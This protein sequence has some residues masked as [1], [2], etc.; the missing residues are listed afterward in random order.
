ML[1]LVITVGRPTGQ[2]GDVPALLRTADVF[3]FTT[4]YREGIPR[5]LLEARL[6]IVGTGLSG[7]TDV[8]C[9]GYRGFLIPPRTPSRS[10]SK[11]LYLLADRQI[12]HA[13]GQRDTR[14]FELD[15]IA[16]RYAFLTQ[17]SWPWSSAV[18]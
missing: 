1:K 14:W 6:P 16:T 15:L 3:A 7:C 17:G 10:A 5:V 13:M 11:I 8:V 12:A 18:R 4:E 9:D 2:R